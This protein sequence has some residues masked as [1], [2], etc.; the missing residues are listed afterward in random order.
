MNPELFKSWIDHQ[1][2]LGIRDDQTSMALF[3]SLHE[4][5]NNIKKL[6]QEKVPK[7]QGF[8]LTTIWFFA[9]VKPQIA[10]ELISY[11]QSWEVEK[12]TYLVYQHIY[13]AL[14]ERKNHLKVDDP[15]RAQIDK[16]ISGTRKLE[17]MMLESKQISRSDIPSAPACLVPQD[18]INMSPL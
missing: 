14:E 13:D 7:N 16:A 5:V 15:N 1:H 17:N 6:I 2:I 8:V 3:T 11:I 9:T 4:D 10:H 12:F 18:W